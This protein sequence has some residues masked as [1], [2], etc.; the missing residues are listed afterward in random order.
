MPPGLILGSPQ[1]IRETPL[2]YIDMIRCPRASHWASLVNGGFPVDV[3]QTVV[4][5]VPLDCVSPARIPLVSLRRD[6]VRVPVTGVEPR[7]IA[8][9]G[10]HPNKITFCFPSVFTAEL[11][12]RRPTS[13]A[14][15]RFASICLVPQGDS[16]VRSLDLHPR[17]AIHQSG[18]LCRMG[19]RQLSTCRASNGESCAWCL[20]SWSVA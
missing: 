3:D 18:Q 8:S 17:F 5:K 1:L 4:Q 11:W 20:V 15:L 6:P 16:R 10:H 13:G 14:T 19:T 12:R 7:D 2:G 9:P